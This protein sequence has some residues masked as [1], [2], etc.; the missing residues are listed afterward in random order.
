MPPAAGIVPL[1][2]GA[3]LNG[4]LARNALGDAGASR[5]A[6]LAHAGR[7]FIGSA[8]AALLYGALGMRLR[9]LPPRACDARCEATSGSDEHLRCLARQELCR[10]SIEGLEGTLAHGSA[11]APAPRDPGML[12]PSG[13]QIEFDGDPM[14]NALGITLAVMLLAYLYVWLPTLLM[15]NAVQ[16][17][18]R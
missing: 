14:L 1:L 13:V 10:R 15:P 9:W 16:P 12:T 17:A 5:V 11:R 4:A 18:Y 2:S 3:D 7:D 8:G 6:S